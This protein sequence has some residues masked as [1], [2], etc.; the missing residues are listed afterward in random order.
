MPNSN[1]VEPK[2]VANAVLKSNIVEQK[3]IKPASVDSKGFNLTE[4]SNM[5]EQRFRTYGAQNQSVVPI[6]NTS[7]VNNNTTEYVPIKGTPRNNDPS[8]IKKLD[9]I[10]DY[11]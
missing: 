6:N 7:I 1:L 3:L 11:R 5:Q 4:L 2:P 9:Q 10:N 8:I